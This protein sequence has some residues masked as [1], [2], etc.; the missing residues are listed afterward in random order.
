MRFM[1]SIVLTSSL[2]GGCGIAPNGQSG[3]DQRRDLAAEI[4]MEEWITDTD[5][6]NY[7]NGDRTDWKW[8]NVA[9]DGTVTVE[10]SFD[11]R[12]AAIVVTLF[13]RYGQ[14]L[15]EKVKNS[16]FSDPVQFQGEI[17]QGK[18]FVQVQARD[19]EDNSVY[20]IRASQQGGSR[21]G[22]IPPPE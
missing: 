17:P 11:N 1:I 18:Y 20:S 4:P 10:V 12:D 3:E 16:G 15:G 9:R 19:T 2:L 21:A 22:A 8:F 6:I 7:A 5:G 14:K 13:N